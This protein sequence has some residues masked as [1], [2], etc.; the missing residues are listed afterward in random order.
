MTI[1]GPLILLAI[2]FALLL[3]GQAIFLLILRSGE[4]K[5]TPRGWDTQPTVI[6]N[7]EHTP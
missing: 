7:H 4:T 6:K 5:K 1:S 2:V 3:T